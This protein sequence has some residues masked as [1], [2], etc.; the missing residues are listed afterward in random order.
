VYIYKITNK[1][2]NK[3][4]IGQTIHSIHSRFLK[5]KTIARV[6]NS[7]YKAI[8]KA[9]NKYGE[10]NFLLEL[11]EECHSMEELNNKE[12]EY[13]KQFNSLSP[14]GYNLC[15]GGFNKIPSP[16]TIQKIKDTRKRRAITRIHMKTGERR[17]YNSITEAIEEGFTNS[18]IT[19]CLSKKHKHHA[20]YYWIYAENEL[21]IIKTKNDLRKRPIIQLDKDGNTVNMFES[22]SAAEKLGFDHSKIILCCQNKRNT[23][24]HYIWKYKE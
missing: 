8:H 9:I 1:I 3:I 19:Y 16:E 18:S 24:K 20:G 21:E 15:T 23:H 17:T 2:N 22:I 13:I 14:N 4:Y 11:V 5:H 12:T 10:D 7:D 6:K